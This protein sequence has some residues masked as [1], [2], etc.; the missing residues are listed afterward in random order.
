[1]C[2]SLLLDQGPG[3]EEVNAMADY[4]NFFVGAVALGLFLWRFIFDCPPVS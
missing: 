3:A 1:M 4:L 2:H